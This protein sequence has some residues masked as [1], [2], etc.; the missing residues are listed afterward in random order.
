MG[1]ARTEGIADGRANPHRDR[2][3]ATSPSVESLEL[4][5]FARTLD[6][7][8]P[9]ERL[10]AHRSCAFDRR[11]MAI[12]AARFPEEAPLRN[13]ELEWIAREMAD[14]DPE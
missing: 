8:T 9:L 7:M 2:H 6:R 13:G 10:R 4:L 12:W 14:L 5:D 1:G 11:E 3:A